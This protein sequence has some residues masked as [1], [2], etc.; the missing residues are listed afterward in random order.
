[1]RELV[2]VPL[3]RGEADP[4]EQVGQRRLEVGRGRAGAAVDLQRAGQV[5]AH[6]VHGVERARTGP[7]RSSAPARRSAR[8]RPPRP[9]P[10]STAPCSRMSPAGARVELGEQ[11]G[12]RGLAGAGLADQRGDPAPAQGEVDVVDRVDGARLV[13]EKRSRSRRRTGKC[14]VRPTASSTTSPTGAAGAFAQRHADVPVSGCGVRV[15]LP[16]RPVA[17]T[18]RTRCQRATGQEAGLRCRITSSALGWVG[19]AARVGVGVVRPAGPVLG[20]V[21]AADVVGGRPGSSASARRR[22]SAACPCAVVRA[23]SSVALA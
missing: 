13:P 10:W 19:W 6:G 2:E 15:P 3:G 22:S 9:W 8:N 21:L 12:D 23:A 4:V 14:L 5:V 17:A 11:P 18:R 20:G 16:G 1:M 7:G